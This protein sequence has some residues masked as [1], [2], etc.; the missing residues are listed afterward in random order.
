MRSKV[1]TIGV[2]PL[3]SPSSVTSCVVGVAVV[4]EVGVVGSVNVIIVEVLV[5]PR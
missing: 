3:P 1:G 2:T 5:Q 4:S